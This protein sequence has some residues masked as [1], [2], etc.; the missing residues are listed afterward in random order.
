MD[1][2]VT[3]WINKR[4]LL[5]L[6]T[7]VF[8]AWVSLDPLNVEIIVPVEKIGSIKKGMKVD[9]LPDS[10]VVDKYKAGVIIV[11]SVIDAASSTFGVRLKQ[12]NSSHGIPAGLKCKIKFP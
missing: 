4:T 9:V 7:V 3:N 2:N 10:A 5:L 6:Q 12:P 1:M 11:D 8:I